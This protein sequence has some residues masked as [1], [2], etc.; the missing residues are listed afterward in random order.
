M[1]RITKFTIKKL[2]GYKNVDIDFVDNTLILVGENGAGKTTVL[3]LFYYLLSGQ[4]SAMVRYE[5]EELS[6]T[7]NS[8]V[9]KLRYS[10]LEKSFRDIEPGLVR[11]LPVAVRQR[12]YALLEQNEGRLVTHE[13]ELLCQEYGIPIHYLLNEM[14]LSYRHSKG[15]STANLRN[16]I[17]SIIGSLDAQVLF[18]PTYRRI[19]QELN[20]IFRGM[21][22]RELKQRRDLL[23]S[24]RNNRTY[25]ELIEF[26]M[27]DVE[28]AIASTL[29]GLNTFAR[30]SLNNLTFGYLGDIVEEHYAKVDLDVIRKASE[31]T[32]DNVLNRIQEHI[33]SNKNKQHLREIINGAQ[34]NAVQSEHTMVICHY[35]TKLMAFQKELEQKEL[36]ITS[37]CRVCNEYMVDKQFKYDFSNFSFTIAPTGSQKL[38]REIKLSHLSSGEKQ[39]VSLFSHLYLS[40]GDKYFVLID[41]P[42]L[43]LS[44]PW[45]RRFLADIRNASLCVG[46][47]AVTHSPFIYDNEL[48]QYAHGLEEFMA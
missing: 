24:R 8:K 13:L 28:N 26:G 4:W 37:F 21:D 39:I 35:F 33:L 5:F 25:V 34:T 41:E 38:N 40:G 46:L 1:E 15:K 48:K 18:L 17:E 43:S 23:T 6:I 31:Q 11:R 12:L 36:Q 47:V 10:D 9:Y 7:I 3:N 22:E 42:E 2:H 45:Q 27:K 20:L 30:E 16:A 19:E 29:S 14:D 32:I 44:V